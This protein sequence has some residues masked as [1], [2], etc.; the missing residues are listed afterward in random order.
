M[1][2]ARAPWLTPAR[3]VCS[4][5]NAALPPPK[6]PSSSLAHDE[7]GSDSDEPM[8]EAD[9]DYASDCD[10]DEMDE[11]EFATRQCSTATGDD[12]TDPTQDSDPQTKCE[13]QCSVV[14][15]CS[16]FTHRDHLMRH[17]ARYH[18]GARSRVNLR[19]TTYAVSNV[20]VSYYR[21]QPSRTASSRVCR[22][23]SASPHDTRRNFTFARLLTRD[24][25]AQ[26]PAAPRATRSVSI[27]LATS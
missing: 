14:T 18:E 19:C 8:S 13:F 2:A 5:A 7:L 10:I 20:V 21:M 25:R 24:S 1:M 27:S 4:T 6:A 23:S 26:S 16:S 22:A 11:E 9:S 17:C 15:C 3:I 12:E